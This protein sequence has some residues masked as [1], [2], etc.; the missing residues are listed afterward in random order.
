[1]SSPLRDGFDLTIASLLQIQ[2]HP[3]ATQICIMPIIPCIAK[4]T[5]GQFKSGQPVKTLTGLPT[6]LAGFK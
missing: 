4:G 1:M 6:V 3:C 5:T 2:I